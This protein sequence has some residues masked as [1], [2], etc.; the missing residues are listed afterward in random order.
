LTVSRWYYPT[1]PGEALRIASLARGA[2]NQLGIENP[3]PHVV[4][5]KA[6]EA[7]GLPGKLGNGVATILVSRT[8][9]SSA[10]LATLDEQIE[11]L[12][13]EYV[14]SPTV[15]ERD[16]YAKILS[17]DD[18]ADFY[19]SYPLDISPPTDDRP[20]FFQMLRF[21]D[22]AASLADNLFDPNRSNL[23]AIKLLGILLVIV[24]VL[25]TLCVVVPLVLRT[26]RGSLRG[27]GALLAFFTAIGMGFMFIEISQMQRLMVMLG[28]PTYALSVVLF[29]LLV[30]TGVGSYVS[31]GLW[32]TDEPGPA[33]RLLAILIAVLVAF[34]A[35]TPVLVRALAGAPTPARIAGASVCLLA[36]GF[37]LGMPFP[38]GMRAAAR[39]AKDLLPWLWGINGAASV[40][41]TVVATVVALTLGISAAFWMG[42]GCYVVAFGAFVV[43]VKPAG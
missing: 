38:F 2:L 11:R 41:C 17:A 6:P 26:R 35:V 36:I 15:S 25:T 42:V 27:S 3:R 24:T 22:F 29:T 12:G 39:K 5:V 33:K 23:E 4:M 16:E 9:F 28:H 32:K 14:V 8:P 7:S 1:R 43:A 13:F 31:G 40:L 19:A 37:F 10:D 20:F 18:P 21:G 30:G 34:G